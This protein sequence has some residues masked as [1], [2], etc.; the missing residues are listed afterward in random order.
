[1]TKPDSLCA[2]VLKGKY[3]PQGE[4]MNAG[5][6]KDASHTWRAILAGRKAL[7]LG[8]IRRIG[9]GSSTNIWEDRWLP[10]GVGNKPLVR[11]AEATGVCVADLLAPDG[12]S[13]DE[14]ALNLNLLPF[15]VEAA[16][17][18]PL[19]CAQADFWAWSRERHGVYSVR[20]AYR[21]LSEA[22]MQQRAHA[23]GASSHSVADNEPRWHQL[24]KQKVPPKV[25]VFWWR[26][27]QDC[28]P[29]RANLHR[30]HV[31][32]IANY[33][34]CGASEETTYHA[35]V[36]CSLAQAF[37]R[38]L[39]ELEGIRLPKLRSRTWPENILDD[40]YCKEKDRVVI[41]CGMWSLW[42]IRNDHYHGKKLIEPA[43]AIDW[44]M[45]ACFHLLIS[46]ENPH[47][48]LTTRME[49][50]QP[51]SDGVLKINCDGAFLS[52][53]SEGSTGAVLRKFD[54]SFLGASARWLSAVS[55][56]LVAEAEACR[57][58]LRLALNRTEFSGVILETDS[59][60]LVS[61]WNSRLQQYSEIAVIL[62]DIAEMI[63]PLPSFCFSHVKRLAN[64]VAHLCV[65]QLSHTSSSF[66]WF[67]QPRFLLHSLE[68]DCN[69]SV[70]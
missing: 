45:D 47:R 38:K 40:T 37:W 31:D 55:S 21:L 18:I 8:L 13:W 20:S 52:G 61:L 57:D 32:P 53:S 24:W 17:R 69:I 70:S 15:D 43:L 26:V 34:F 42:N 51:P 64:H 44:S 30:R 49:K 4:F 5:K 2:R 58:G 1:M 12:R 25:R 36:E 68:S 3:F 19:G 39:K 28:I 65:K 33:G 35:L 60:Q 63:S 22:E 66:L 46:Q 54:G 10:S 48:E 16:K 41:L 6:K 9:D 67:Q 23:L 14:D 27:M 62:E 56:A 59:L 29:C 50:W 11:K 7:E